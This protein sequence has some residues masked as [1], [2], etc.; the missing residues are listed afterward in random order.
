LQTL[1]VQKTYKLLCTGVRT[2]IWFCK[3][4]ILAGES[5]GTISQSLQRRPRTSSQ[6]GH[7]RWGKGAEKVSKKRK[8]KGPVAF[9]RKIIEKGAEKPTQI[10]GVPEERMFPPRRGEKNFQETHSEIRAEVSGNSPGCESQ[11]VAKTKV[12]AGWSASRNTITLIKKE[13]KRGR[14]ASLDPFESSDCV[15]NAWI[16]KSV[17]RESYAGPIEKEKEGK[18]G[19]PFYCRTVVCVE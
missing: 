10:K 19:T 4:P 7:S 9:Q 6:K 13:R 14:G 3:R 5:E 1:P 11:G 2:R 12:R 8:K 18:E 15:S 16:K 17:K